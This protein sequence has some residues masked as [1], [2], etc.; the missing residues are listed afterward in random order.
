M[1]LFLKLCSERW[2]QVFFVLGNHDLWLWSKTQRRKYNWVSDNKRNEMRNFAN[3]IDNLHFLDGDVI[4]V[5]GKRIAGAM[6]WY[7]LKDAFWW[8]SFSNDSKYILPN[9]FPDNNK[10]ASQD[11]FFFKTLHGD[12]D[13]LVTHV[14]P[15]HFRQ[16]FNTPQ[17]CYY[18]YQKMKV[19]SIKYWICGH[20]HFY[21][22]TPFIFSSWLLANPY[23][24]PREDTLKRL[25]QIEI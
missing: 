24:Y 7:E 12:I 1:K 23:G 10:R 13:L 20:Q 9:T 3:S 19:N 17:D 15:I 5:G 4:T 8:F 18:H 11:D 14:P 16:N 25:K 21:N 22:K 2:E 6:N